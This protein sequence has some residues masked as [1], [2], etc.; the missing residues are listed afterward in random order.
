MQKTMLCL[1]IMC[2]LIAIG[3]GSNTKTVANGPIVWLGG[4]QKTGSKSGA[5]SRMARAM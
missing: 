2:L 5:K 4:K 3:C 1:I